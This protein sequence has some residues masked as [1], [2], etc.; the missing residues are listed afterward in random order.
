[1]EEED[2]V[3]AADAELAL[4]PTLLPELLTSRSPLWKC[5]FRAWSVGTERE[6]EREI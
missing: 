6:R 3:A 4:T 5:G 1:M 2:T